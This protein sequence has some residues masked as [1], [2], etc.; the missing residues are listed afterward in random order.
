LARATAAGDVIRY[1]RMKARTTTA[2]AHMHNGAHN[3]VPV[4]AKCADYRASR[5]AGEP[6]LHDFL[7]PLLTELR[8]S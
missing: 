7:R 4:L 6:S 5:S 3:P 2:E 8:R 1:R